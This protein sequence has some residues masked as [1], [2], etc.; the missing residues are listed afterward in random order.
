MAFPSLLTPI[1]HLFLNESDGEQIAF[2]SDY[3][4]AR[5]RTSHLRFANTTHYHIDFDINIG[6]DQ[7]Q[8][9]F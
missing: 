8:L 6:L 7:N 2:E 4:E 1:S 9:D 5:E 3:L